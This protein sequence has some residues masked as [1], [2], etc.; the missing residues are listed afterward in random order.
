MDGNDFNW[1]G[2]FWITNCTILFHALLQGTVGLSFSQLG[3]VGLS[4]SQLSG[5]EVF[6]YLD[7]SKANEFPTV[8]FNLL[9]LS[10][11]VL[12][13]FLSQKQQMLKT[14]S[15]YC[16]FHDRLTVSEN[17]EEVM[18]E[19][20]AL[21]LHH[22]LFVLSFHFYRHPNLKSAP[23]WKWNLSFL[24]WNLRFGF[25]LPLKLQ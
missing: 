1:R 14:F 10:I 5:V 2:T 23:R 24:R 21:H 15:L 4:F 17:H 16:F 12:S 9:T 18:Q 11:Y 20:I 25:L 7:F 3:T 19:T 6:I 22:P 8:Q 13:C